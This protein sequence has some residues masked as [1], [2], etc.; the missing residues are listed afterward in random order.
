MFVRDPSGCWIWR[1]RKSKP[2]GYPQFGKR[3]A[4]RFAYELLV[5]P[6]P[7]GLTID[8]LCRVPACVNPTHMEPVTQAENSRRASAANLRP[9]CPKGH[10]FTP[11]NIYTR[12][13]GGRVCRT[14]TL[15]V[16]AYRGPKRKRVAA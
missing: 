6:I 14:C 2:N 8:H 11:E 1:G 12:R 15:T 13:N 9:A 4:H 7:Q 16:W 5:E 3:W 10:E